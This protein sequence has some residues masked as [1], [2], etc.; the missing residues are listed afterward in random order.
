MQISLLFSDYF[1]QV[2]AG[3]IEIDIPDG[4]GADPGD[5]VKSLEPTV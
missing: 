2:F 4:E 5:K 1:F 3:I